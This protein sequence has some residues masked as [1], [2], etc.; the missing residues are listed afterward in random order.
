MWKT[1]E[2]IRK[3]PHDFKVKYKLYPREEGGRR[4][5]YQGLRCDFSYLGDDIADGI[6]IIHPEFEDINGNIILD[7]D[8][9]VPLESTARMW[10]LSPQ[11]RELVHKDRISIGTKGFMMEGPRKIGK[12]E[13]IEIA[14]LY[15]NNNQYDMEKLMKEINTLHTL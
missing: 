11:M 1:Y 9:P 7:T 10:I 2:S 5:T 6:Y 4:I 15:S 12:L 8:E 14:G 13:V 3:H